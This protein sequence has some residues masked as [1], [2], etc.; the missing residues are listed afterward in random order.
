MVSLKGFVKD[1][2][3]FIEKVSCTAQSHMNLLER[4]FQSS[5]L[6]ERLEAPM[7]FIHDRL[8][9]IKHETIDGGHGCLAIK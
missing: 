4:F 5:L 2:E 7:M 6:V 1:S 8:L 3:R 9:R